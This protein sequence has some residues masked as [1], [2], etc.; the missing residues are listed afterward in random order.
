MTIQAPRKLT[1]PRMRKTI[2]IGST[3][4]AKAALPE[5]RSVR[6]PKR[7]AAPIMPDIAPEAPPSGASPYGWTA[8][9]STTAASP[10]AAKNKANQNQPRRLASG[11]PKAA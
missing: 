6:N 3:G 2:A 4:P 11:D 8:Q 9:N 7:A 5:E 10:V 1:T